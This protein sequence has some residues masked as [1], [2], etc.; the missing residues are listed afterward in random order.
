MVLF[1]SYCTPLYCSYLWTEYKKT[2]SKIRVLLITRTYLYLVSQIE[3]V[4]VQC[5]KNLNICNFEVVLR[6]NIWNFI[7]RLENCTNS[8]IQI[9]MQSWYTKFDIWNYWHKTLYTCFNINCT[10]FYCMEH[11][12]CVSLFICILLPLYTYEN[13]YMS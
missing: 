11:I 13:N 1:N 2:F 5:M 12:V 4:Q 10:S 9:L 8:I 6:T 7:Q 3:A